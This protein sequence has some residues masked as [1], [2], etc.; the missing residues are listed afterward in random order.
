GDTKIVGCS[1]VIDGRDESPRNRA[2]A[3]YY[4][5]DAWRAKDDPDRAIADYSE[6]IRL[7]P[8]NAEVYVNRGIAWGKKKD[9]DRAIAD[10]SEAIQLNPKHL[11][12]HYSRGFA[13]HEKKDYDRAIADYSEVIRLNTANTTGTPKEPAFSWVHL[14]RALS[15]EK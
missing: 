8:K 9:Y 14:Y 12:A 5:G 2:M 1:G 7:D 4:R 3:Y 15:Y 6:A 11:L 10:Y 13:W